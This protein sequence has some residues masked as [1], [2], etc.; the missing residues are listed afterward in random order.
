MAVM[1]MGGWGCSGRCW[2]AGRSVDG[3][4]EVAED[5][6]RPV[7]GIEHIVVS[8]KTIRGRMVV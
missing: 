5:F 4:K 1:A 2:R 8:L 7:G 6:M 3:L